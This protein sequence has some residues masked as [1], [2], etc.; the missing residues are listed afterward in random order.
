MSFPGYQNAFGFPGIYLA[1]ISA[2][3]LLDGEGSP[4]LTDQYRRLVTVSSPAVPSPATAGYDWVYT[5]GALEHQGVA[6]IGASLLAQAMGSID[7]SEATGVYFLQFYNT[8]AVPADGVTPLLSFPIDHTTAQVS[9]FNVVI[10]DT[11]SAGDDR[12]TV[13]VSWC[14]SSTQFT[15]TAVA[16]NKAALT[17]YGY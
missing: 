2:K 9:S 13:G 11:D 4:L 16:S 7:P 8:A 1:D 14:I 12:F 3:P 6:H 17:I 5:S 10:D 15:K